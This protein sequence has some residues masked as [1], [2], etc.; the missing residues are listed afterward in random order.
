MA[1]DKT[2]SPRPVVLQLRAAG[3]SPVVLQAALRVA[4]AL[5]SDFESIFIEDDELLSLAALPFAREITMSGRR[6]RPLT[7]EAIEREMRAASSAVRREIEA[8]ARTLDVKTQFSVVRDQLDLAL[9]QV[10]ER[11]GVLVIG[12]PVSSSAGR[13]ELRALASCMAGVSACLMAGGRV[14]QATG[15]VVALVD[16]PARFD[17]IVSMAARFAGTA[18]G[19]LAVL[20]MEDALGGPEELGKRLAGIVGGERRVRIE[21]LRTDEPGY[22][23]YSV[24]RLGGGLLVAGYGGRMIAGDAAVVSIATRLECPLLLLRPGEREPAAA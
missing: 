2:S 23:A 4:A 16:D 7:A 3:T 17:E 14:R 1:K 9:R 20:G 6:L 24:R 12:E 13:R 5:Q 10:G 8:L 22:V 18:A 11:A 19:E 21:T 15:S